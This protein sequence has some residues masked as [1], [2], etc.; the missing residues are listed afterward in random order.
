[1]TIQSEAAASLIVIKGPFR[2][3]ALAAAAAS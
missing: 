2:P 3:P 1:M